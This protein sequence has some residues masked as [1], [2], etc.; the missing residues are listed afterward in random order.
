MYILLINLIC[1]FVCWQD[2]KEKK[3]KEK[4]QTDRYIELLRN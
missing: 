2:K 4:K 3:K 1:E